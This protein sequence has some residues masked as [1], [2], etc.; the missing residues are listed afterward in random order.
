MRHRSLH[1]AAVAPALVALLLGACTFTTPKAPRLEGKRVPVMVQ[2][3]NLRADSALA[4][5]RVVVAPPVANGAWALAGGTATHAPYHLALGA[6]PRRAFKVSAGRGSTGGR[7]L[8]AQPVV[9]A[10]GRIFVL[11]AH[12][13]IYV[14]DADTGTRLWARDLRPKEEREGTLGAGLAAVGGKVFVT[15]GFAQV[16]ALDAGDGR[17]LWRKSLSAPFRSAPMVADGRVFAVSTDNRTHALDAETGK[18]LWTH[19]GTAELVSLLGGASPAYDRGTLVVAYSSGELFALKAGTGRQIWSE[20]LSQRRRTSGI[21]TIAD[22]LASP[23]IDRGRVFAVSNSGYM[24]ALSLASGRRLWQR[25]IGATSTPWTAGAYLYLV[26][27]DNVLVCLRRR[28]GGVVWGRSLDRYRDE[29]KRRD[30]ISWSGPV[31]AGDRLILAGTNKKVL[32]ISPYTGDLLGQIKLA[33]G[34]EIAPIIARGTL[35][36]LTRDAELIA[37]R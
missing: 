20:F 1:L 24:V 31:L 16:L 12:A 4:D 25:R 2:G 36:L 35:Y 32:A 34:V 17:V 8:L 14:F 10:E 18:L 13:R 5:T 29:K 6:A 23:V 26:T 37:W 28:D 9:D 30:W 7:R 11:D 33:D 22:I 15:T 3:S 21:G 19:R 27:T